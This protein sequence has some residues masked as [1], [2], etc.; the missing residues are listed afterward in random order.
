MACRYGG[1]EFCLLMPDT[2][3]AAAQ[4]K[5]SALLD[6]WRATDFTVKGHT[7]RGF[8]FSGGVGDSTGE[9]GQAEA[10]LQA[11]DHKLLEAKRAGRA[12]VLAVVPDTEQI[13]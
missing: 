13:D 6:A 8:T 5:I 9:A 7:L 2:D 10:L 1:E 4:R 3:A 12:R 11:A